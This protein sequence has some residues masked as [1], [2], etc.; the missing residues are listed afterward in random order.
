MWYNGVS[1]TTDFFAIL[2]ALDNREIIS[3]YPDLWAK[4]CAS[5]SKE[6]NEEDAIIRKGFAF[7]GWNDST[8]DEKRALFRAQLSYVELNGLV[9]KFNQLIYNYPLSD[10]DQTNWYSGGKVFG[11][12]RGLADDYEEMELIVNQAA[13]LLISYIQLTE[14]YYLNEPYL[15]F[16]IHADLID[17][18]TIQEVS[19]LIRKNRWGN[20][21]A[22]AIIDAEM[23]KTTS[24][25]VVKYFQLSFCKLFLKFAKEPEGSYDL[26]D[27][28]E[29]VVDATEEESSSL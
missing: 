28:C 8:D 21:R 12:L 20:N 27:F 24:E 5:L 19:N 7:A 29:R 13:N 2:K 9:P 11:T 25:E 1:M 3:P 6:I 18:P 15:H 10:P 14:R 16:E 4:I 17:T 22:D 23:S 26:L